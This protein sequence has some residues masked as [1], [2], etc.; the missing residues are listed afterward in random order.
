MA[1]KLNIICIII[2]VGIGLF[3][4]VVPMF[5]WSYYSLESSLTTCSVEWE[6]RSLNVVS[7]N[8][9]IFAVV[10]LIPLIVIIITGI[11]LI[12]KVFYSLIL[13]LGVSI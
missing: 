13:N 9:S 10:Y 4:S 3:W 12:L 1:F 7:Y 11:F 5:G 2:S 8:V 6:D